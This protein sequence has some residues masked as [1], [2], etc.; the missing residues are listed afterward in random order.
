M[1]IGWAIVT[2]AALATAWVGVCDTVGIPW[3]AMWA[4]CFACG[5]I[6]ARLTP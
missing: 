4:G 1:G 2:G 3:W 6:G 5:V